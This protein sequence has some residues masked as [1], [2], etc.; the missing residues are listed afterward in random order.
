MAAFVLGATELVSYGA[1]P[2][3]I[4]PLVPR[5]DCSA[6]KAAITFRTSSA[7]AAVMSDPKCD[8]ALQE[9]SLFE[10][11][12]SMHARIKCHT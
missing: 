4:C 9:P 1:V 2:C 6:D 11:M 5:H 12:L 7:I 8:R 10:L 3:N